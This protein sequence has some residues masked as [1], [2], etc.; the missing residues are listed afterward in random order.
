[1]TESVLRQAYD[2]I[3][4][5]ARSLDERSSWQPTRCAGWCVRDLLFHHLGDAQRALVAL[6]TP[7]DGPAD[8]TAVSYWTDAPGQEDPESRGLRA[9]RTM[10]SAYRLDHLVQTYVETLAA[11]VTAAERLAPK[12][13]LATQGHVLTVADVA[14]T[15]AVE[16]AIHHLD[17][18][19]GL[20]QPGPAVGSLAVVRE[21][22]DG[23]LG[24]PTPDEWPDVVWVL[25]A[26]GRADLSAEARDWLGSDASR[27]PL[28]H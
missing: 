17:L 16:A 27:L 14:C 26:T 12:A 18:V 13:L 11:V 3:S 15:L 21:V 22:V 19:V 5:V 6:A 2:D 4:A 8:R 25:A 1:M 23:L 7:A 20:A 10:A 24:R 28:L 9:T